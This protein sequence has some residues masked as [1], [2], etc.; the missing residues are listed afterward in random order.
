[1]DNIVAI[2][3]VQYEHLCFHAEL[4]DRDKTRQWR[5]TE[6]LARAFEEMGKSGWIQEPKVGTN[7]LF[8]Y[9]GIKRKTTQSH[10]PAPNP[11]YRAIFYPSLLVANFV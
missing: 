1:M 6:E 8:S 10:P 3:S 9:I 2:V 4:N 5:E 11:H 7:A